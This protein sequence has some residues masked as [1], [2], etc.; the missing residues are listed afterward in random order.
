MIV[1]VPQSHGMGHFY[2]L[3]N[4]VKRYSNK[5][6]NIF[7]LL[8]DNFA[9]INIKLNLCSRDELKKANKVVIDSNDIN[10][11]REIIKNVHNNKVIWITDLRN[12]ISYDFDKVIAPF[13]I[14]HNK[15]IFKGLEYI[16]VSDLKEFQHVKCINKVK[17]I[18]VY[19]GSLDETNNLFFI[20]YKLYSLNLINKYKFNVLIGR[21]YKFRSFIDE[22]FYNQKMKNL[23]F[24]KSNLK[25]IY[26]FIRLNDVLITCCNNTTFEALYYGVP[27]INVVQNKIQ[28]ENAKRLEIKYGFPNL[29]FYPDNQKILNVF[30]GEF[31]ANI[32]NY[33]IIAKKI[34][35]GK[36]S[37]RIANLIKGV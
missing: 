2:R 1:F 6:S 4:I 25:S 12:N 37:E 11:V 16:V 34:I 21:N 3:T 19:F 5:Y 17:N 7:F 10:F 8:N 28:Y 30:E 14:G 24:Y 33:S 36:G 18:G 15:K 26:D 29:G 22:F 13:Y 35:D 32:S 27:V 31:F 23:K 9:S 20:L